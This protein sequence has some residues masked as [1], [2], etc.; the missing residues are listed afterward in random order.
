MVPATDAV[1]YDADELDHPH[2]TYANVARI[3]HDAITGY[4]TDVR[5]GRQ[6]KGGI[7]T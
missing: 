7:H 1:G 2:D 3:A 4:A 6:I 5:A